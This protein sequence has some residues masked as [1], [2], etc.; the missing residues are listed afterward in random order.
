MRLQSIIRRHNRRF[1]A[2]RP[3]SGK[4][5]KTPITHTA[6]TASS[7][8]AAL[9]NWITLHTARTA[10]HTAH[11]AISPTTESD[12]KTEVV[13]YYLDLSFSAP[14]AF[15]YEKSL[16][17]T[18]PTFSPT[19]RISQEH[20][21]RIRLSTLSRVLRIGTNYSAAQGLLLVKHRIDSF[22]TAAFCSLSFIAL[23]S[24]ALSGSS[25]R[26]LALHQIPKSTDRNQLRP[27]E[28]L[29]YA[30]LLRAPDSQKLQDPLSCTK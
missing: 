16:Q 12:T 18:C 8:T 7:L 26:L 22:T 29:R 3:S 21:P 23:F 2:E 11:T 25:P 30:K 13:W 28:Q 9:R 14:K 24:I 5:V 19:I 15:T 4:L 27:L 20:Y 17:D 1:H 6:D 10:V